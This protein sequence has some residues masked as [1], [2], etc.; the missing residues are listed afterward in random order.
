MR[1]VNFAHGE[2]FMAGGFVFFTFFELLHVPVIGS[3]LLSIGFLFLIGMGI[4]KV[5]FKP[6][7]DDPL[8]S[9]VISL[10]LAI[11]L[12]NIFLIIF[13]GLEK[14]V[15][16]PIGGVINLRGIYIPKSRVLVIFFSLIFTF[17]L[18][19]FLKWTRM[20]YSMRAVAQDREAS[21]LQGIKIDKVSYISFGIGS[22]LAALG[23]A[24]VGILF[25]LSPFMGVPAVT[26]AFI[27]VILGGM[28]S[29]NGTVIAGI[30]LGFSESIIASFTRTS[31]AD[32]I[33]FLLLI[34]ILIF[35]PQGIMGKNY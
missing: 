32:M 4:E 2:I 28:G 6:F 29:L 18:F 5:F 10:G 31:F 9:L 22:A 19:A 11:L 1:I 21:A 34:I 24:L 17:A 12:Q 33:S 16:N 23:G 8:N 7:R 30:I 13:G 20:G 3:L 25:D 35:R 15:Q 26:K 27:V 14:S